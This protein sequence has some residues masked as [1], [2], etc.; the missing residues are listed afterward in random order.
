[1]DLIPGRTTAEFDHVLAELGA[2][3]SFREAARIMN[4]FV[5][6]TSKHNHTRV[7]SRLAAVADRITERD[8]RAP[9]RMSRSTDGPV[10]VF[11]DGTYVRAVPGFQT[12]HFE[13]VMGRIET[14]GRPASHFATMPNISASRHEIVRGAVKAQGWLPGREVV[15]FS[16]GDPSLV[17]IVR[18][19]TN[20]SV[21]H[22]LDWFHASMR[23][24]HLRES[25]RSLVET[26]RTGEIEFKCAAA[27]FEAM[28]SL[29]WRGKIITSR[30]LLRAASNDLRRVDPEA[31]PRAIVR[32]IERLVQMIKDFD[33]YL[34]LNQR[35]MPNYA[36]RY[37]KGLPVSSSRAESTANALVNRRLNKRRQMRWS[38]MGA[39]RVLQARVA[40]LDRRDYTTGHCSSP[41][42]PNNSS[43]LLNRVERSE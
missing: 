9:Y 22:I 38:P 34:E 43:T 27:H 36:E 31:H 32:K 16:D 29:L 37:R 39:Q 7:R 2:R 12:R 24:Q 21:H 26:D 33:K 1:M 40:V 13:V 18:R 14:K 35:A 19:A 41:H 20:G 28:R 15:V 23:V 11:I 30:W 17:D 5:P 42:D 8:S 10:S 6:A 4:M 3:H 25:C